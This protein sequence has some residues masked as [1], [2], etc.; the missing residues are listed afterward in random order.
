MWP[1][2]S[3]SDGCIQFL[4][5]P[6][7]RIHR[8]RA[9][10]KE[11]VALSSRNVA[12]HSCSSDFYCSPSSAPTSAALSFSYCRPATLP[13]C[14]PRHLQRTNTAFRSSSAG[15][16]ALSSG[17]CAAARRAFLEIT[18]PRCRDSALQV[19]Y[20]PR[21]GVTALRV[22]S[23]HCAREPGECALEMQNKLPRAR[24]HRHRPPFSRSK[25]KRSESARAFRAF[26][27]R[28]SPFPSSSETPLASGRFI[29]ARAPSVKYRFPPF[30][31]R[32]R[33]VARAFPSFQRSP[34]TG[35]YSAARS[36]LAP[37][38]LSTVGTIS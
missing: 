33:A 4:L 11:S 17:N 32:T 23:A 38:R 9:G 10:S 2:C 30:G 3:A 13:T 37:S 24:A 8:F 21:D 15:Q 18:L 14:S 16:I 7:N 26:R 35:S 31:R 34:A 22:R 19:W 28:E 1:F 20:I 12:H 27:G 29:K 36:F 5:V 6:A 25:W